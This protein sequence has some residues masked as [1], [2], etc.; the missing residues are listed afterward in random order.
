MFRSATASV[1]RTVARRAYATEAAATANKLTL[2]LVMPH[3]AL[4]TKKE[5]QQVNLSGA[6]GDIGILA[7]HVPIIEQLK[8]GV[9]EVIEK[10]G[11]KNK[12]FVSGG[13]AVVHPDSSLNINAVEAFPLDSF[14]KE[15]I[16]AGLEEANRK[17]GS[18]KDAEAIAEAKV[19]VEVY[20][21][22]QAAT[23]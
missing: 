22:L 13:F 6:N 20:T 15:A 11:K 14:D 21:A 10:D 5:V 4:Y 16:R 7:N 19:E 8:P 9:V 12:F 18:A 1:L 23:K 3:Q 2:N 17:A